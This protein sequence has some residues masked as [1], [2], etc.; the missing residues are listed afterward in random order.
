MGLPVRVC[1]FVKWFGMS[2]PPEGS[3][4]VISKSSTTDASAQWPTK[5]FG[6]STRT[7]SN[8]FRLSEQVWHWRRHRS[9]AAAPTLGVGRVRVPGLTVTKRRAS[10][11]Y[12]RRQ[13]LHLLWK[14]TIKSKKCNIKTKPHNTRTGIFW[15]V[16]CL[17][18]WH[19]EVKNT[20][21]AQLNPPYHSNQ[22]LKKNSSILTVLL[23]LTL[24]FTLLWL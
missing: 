17:R 23:P 4:F 7:F 21:K 10:N 12:L 22:W 8:P 20:I 5:S 3:S 15:I 11:A 14:G 1:Q 13:S 6:L 9:I 24:C 16:Q 2:W 18:L 19:T